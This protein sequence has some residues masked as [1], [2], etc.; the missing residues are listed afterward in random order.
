[1]IAALPMYERAENRA[2]HDR[3]WQAIRTH[4]NDAPEAL[5]REGDLW[6]IWRSPDLVMAQT[7]GFPYRARLHGHVTL[8]GTPDF[9]LPDCPPGYYNSLFLTHVDDP[10]TLPELNGATFAFN[11]PMSQSGWAAPV[12]HMQAMA[13]TPGAVQQSGA[14][15]ASAGMVASGDADFCAVDART[16]A[17]LRD[18]DPITEQVR[19]IAAT[20]PTPGLPYITARTR[21]P[22][23]IA[24]AIRAAIAGLDPGDRAALGLKGLIDIPAETYLAVPSPEP[25]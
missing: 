11:E 5:T 14:H 15:V 21:D 3:F 16:W 6:D 7:C 18:C 4:L 10:R 8:I 1:M 19:P 20:T 23:P 17:M 25:V 9:G 2:A 12:V 13:M 24:A 22:K